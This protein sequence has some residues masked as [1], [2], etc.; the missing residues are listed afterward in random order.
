MVQCASVCSSVCK[1]YSLGVN[2]NKGNLVIHYK[3][4]I[5]TSAYKRIPVIGLPSNF[6]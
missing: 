2:H 3:G 4:E 1:Q 6:A 5:G